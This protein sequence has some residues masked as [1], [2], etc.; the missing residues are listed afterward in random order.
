MLR[1]GLVKR[2]CASRIQNKVYAQAQKSAFQ[3][4]SIKSFSVKEE[5][6]KN[7]DTKNANIQKHSGGTMSPYMQLSK[8]RLSALVVMT[9]GAGILMAGPPFDP[10]LTLVTVYYISKKF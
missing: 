10:L 5:L 1:S 3:T 4:T 6:E 2:I 7:S 8:A 9:T